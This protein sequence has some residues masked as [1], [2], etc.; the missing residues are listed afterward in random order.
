MRHSHSARLLV[1]PVLL[2]LIPLFTAPLPVS[3]RSDS[4]AS[5]RSA[6][7]PAYLFVKLAEGEMVPLER[8]ELPTLALRKPCSTPELQR[9]LARGPF[10]QRPAVT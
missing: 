4:R 10:Q 3:E 5:S 6:A 7:A 8:F 9:R 1:L 2:H